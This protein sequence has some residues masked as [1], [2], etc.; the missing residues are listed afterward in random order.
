MR[1]K[2]TGRN[3]MSNLTLVGSLGDGAGRTTELGPHVAFWLMR[4]IY[5]IKQSYPSSSH[6]SF[7]P[8]KVD[9]T[10]IMVVE[11]SI[12]SNSTTCNTDNS[13]EG[14]YYGTPND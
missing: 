11:P 6:H 12:I 14:C 3:R 1:L 7:C 9:T 10:F 2:A 8:R 4:A 5:N 13:N